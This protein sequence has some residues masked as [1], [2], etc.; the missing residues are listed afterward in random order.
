MLIVQNAQLK[1][2][3]KSIV[4]NAQLKLK[5]KIKHQ[6]NKCWLYKMRN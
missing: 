1:L 5:R 3:G 6:K 4:Q 2:K